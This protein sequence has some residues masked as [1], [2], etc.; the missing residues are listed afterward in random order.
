MVLDTSA[1]LVILLNDLQKVILG[2]E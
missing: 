1:V 2:Q